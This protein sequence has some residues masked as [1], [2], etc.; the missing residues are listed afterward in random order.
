MRSLPDSNRI[1]F[2][3][4][5]FELVQPSGAV[6]KKYP[7]EFSEQCVVSIDPAKRRWKIHWC[8]D[9]GWFFLS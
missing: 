5:L 6:F 9:S 4:C 1:A 8:V 7:D 3:H 2:L